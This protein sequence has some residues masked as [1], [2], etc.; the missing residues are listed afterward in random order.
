MINYN[1]AGKA[2]VHCL[3]V[4]DAKLILVDD[5]PGFRERIEGERGVLEGEL[6]LKICIMDE[7]ARGEIR[8]MKTER[9]SDE[10]RDGVKGDW[11][12]CM[13][14]TRYVWAVGSWFIYFLTPD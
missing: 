3:K 1:L 14:Y 4:S 10:Y 12:M 7:Q 6:G 13:F 8:S 2:L 9:P 5:E 11:P